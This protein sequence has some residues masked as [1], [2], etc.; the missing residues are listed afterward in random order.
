M[1]TNL[2]R[3]H[4]LQRNTQLVDRVIYVLGFIAVLV[5]WLTA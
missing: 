3:T 1:Q 4:A 5:I 2:E